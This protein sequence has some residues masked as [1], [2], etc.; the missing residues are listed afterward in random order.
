MRLKRQAALS[1][2]R[3]P[4]G[5]TLIEVLVALT[6]LAVGLLGLGTLMID[7]LAGSRIGLQHAEAVVLAADVGERIRANRAGADAYALG[8]GTTVAA[9]AFDCSA[10]GECSAAQV[11]ARDLYDWQQSVRD[12]L[13][14]AETSIV[15]SPVGAG[16]ARRYEIAIRW[17]QSGDDDRASVALVVQT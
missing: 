12:A 3:R 5:F 9:P 17:V 2:R 16:P 13:P 11:A 6:V 7:G 1:P 4:G 15:S 14:G 10:P 8:A